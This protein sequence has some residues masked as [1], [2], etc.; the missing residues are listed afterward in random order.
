MLD[1]ALRFVRGVPCRPLRRAVARGDARWLQAVPH[2]VRRRLDLGG[3][4]VVPL[5]VEIGGGDFPSPGYVHVDANW[6]ARELHRVAKAWKLPF[7]DASVHELLAVHVLEHVHPGRV[8]ATLQEWR[9]VLVP[10]GY[11]EVHVPNAATVFPAFL[12]AEA[13]QKWLLLVGVFGMTCQADVDPT[14]FPFQR[15]Q[16]IYDFRLLEHVVLEAGFA[17][18]ENVSDRVEDRHNVAWRALGLVDRV[19]LVV[20][21]HTSHREDRMTIAAPS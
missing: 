13:E 2:T 3:A 8:V 18:V 14:D 20:R 21:A 10:G 5:R 4:P 1:T 16:A 7:D 19:S 12:S 11:A 9:R 15:H 6:R 17:D